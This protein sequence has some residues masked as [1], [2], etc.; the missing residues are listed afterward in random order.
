MCSRVHFRFAPTSTCGCVWGDGRKPASQPTDKTKL[1]MHG[2]AALGQST[3]ASLDL[4]SYGATVGRRLRRDET[5]AAAARRARANRP[6]ARRPAGSLLNVR[7]APPPL[8]PD[9]S[10]STALAKGRSE[11]RFGEAVIEIELGFTISP[12]QPLQIFS[13][14]G[15]EHCEYSDRSGRLPPSL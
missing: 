7:P 12:S 4:E 8:P 9:E 13:R 1:L 3:I 14:T 5:P 11:A 15:S 2:Y 10:L 6:P